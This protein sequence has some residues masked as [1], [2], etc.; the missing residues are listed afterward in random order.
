[1]PLELPANTAKTLQS[2][3]IF[4]NLATSSCLFLPAVALLS[5]PMPTGPGVL[6]E[7]YVL[8]SLLLF[9]PLSGAL[10]VVSMA[11]RLL[12]LA[13]WRLARRLEAVQ[14]EEA[15]AAELLRLCRNHYLAAVLA[16]LLIVLAGFVLGAALRVPALALPYSFV[17]LLCLL[18]SR[19][20]ALADVLAKVARQ[21][22]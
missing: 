7:N 6:G 1:M 11:F 3:K 8:V 20:S 22:R 21:R 19:P 10:A 14:G 13:P 4:W 2:A 5:M 9:I 15:K 12:G 17:A 18:L 16:A